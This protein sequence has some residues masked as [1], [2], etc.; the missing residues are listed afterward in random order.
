MEDKTK[1]KRSPGLSS[2]R[3]VQLEANAHRLICAQ[4]TRRFRGARRCLVL[5][6]AVAK[7]ESSLVARRRLANFANAGREVSN[8]QL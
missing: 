5:S 4:F 3:V 8:I 6:D 7:S 1:L 2:P